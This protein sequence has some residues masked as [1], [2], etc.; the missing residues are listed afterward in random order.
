[1]KFLNKL[2]RKY[3]KYAIKNLSL[4]V[5]GMYIIGFAIYLMVP[6]AVNSL[7]LNPY[8]IL[9]GE[10]WRLVTFLL[11]PPTTSLIFIVFALLF[12]YNI[13]SSLEAVWGAFRFNLYLFTG[14][15][16]TIVGA[17]LVY[18]ITGSPDIYMNTTYVNL[19][20]F[21]AYAALFPNMEVLVYFIL[22]VKIKWL[23]YVDVAFLLVAFFLGGIGTKIAI[24]VSLL[25]FILFYFATRNYKKYSPKEVKRKKKFKKQVKTATNGAR[26]QCYICKRTELDDSNLEFRFCSKCGGN[27]EYCQDHLFTHIHIK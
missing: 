18:F 19:S 3:G 25:N 27:H 20:L 9:H 1:M 14:I 15:L 11:D 6:T 24:V 21:L 23:A 5:I 12:Y 8:M 7:S 13:C 17:F 4:Y 2:E 16:G 10:V 26:H 22:P